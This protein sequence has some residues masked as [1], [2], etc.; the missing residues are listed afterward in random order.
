MMRF[1]KLLL[2]IMLVGI[3]GFFTVPYFLF[4]ADIREDRSEIPEIKNELGLVVERFGN[5]NSWDNDV[6]FRE[7][8]KYNAQN[9][10]IESRYYSLQDENTAFTIVDS[11]DYTLTKYSYDSAGQLHL[12]RRYHRSY[13]SGELVLF[14]T[15]NHQTQRG[16][17][18]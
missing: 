17:E 11:S 3:I 4:L 7:L 9:Q 16:Q 14:F 1:L 8:L 13:E 5:E 2:G 6:N 12:E 18:E 15:Y 10:L